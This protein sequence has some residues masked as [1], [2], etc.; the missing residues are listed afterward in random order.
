M[1][2]RHPYKARFEQKYGT[3]HFL[4]IGLRAVIGTTA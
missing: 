4:L 1:V 3:E 2:A